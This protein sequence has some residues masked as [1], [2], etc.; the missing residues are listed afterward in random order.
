MVSNSAFNTE[1]PDIMPPKLLTEKYMMFSKHLV[2]LAQ[3]MLNQSKKLISK[4]SLES[5][6]LP[7]KFYILS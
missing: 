1:S 4:N 3:I 7:P 2:S 6:N 5:T